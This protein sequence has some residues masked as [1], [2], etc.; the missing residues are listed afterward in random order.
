[1][2]FVPSERPPPALGVNINVAEQLVFPTTRSA[3]AMVK[4]TTVTMLPMLPALSA[5]DELESKKVRNVTELVTGSLANFTPFIVIVIDP[6]VAMAIVK[7]ETMP[8]IVV[9]H[10]S[11][12]EV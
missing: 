5:A 10:K 6:G 12:S 4:L 1:M 11:A 2:V 3:A 7:L 8:F 9:P